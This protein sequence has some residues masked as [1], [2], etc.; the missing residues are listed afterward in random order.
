MFVHHELSA[1]RNDMLCA[2]YSSSIAS[3]SYLQKDFCVIRGQMLLRGDNVTFRKFH[4][5]D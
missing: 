2:G 4:D 3:F 1:K 5:L